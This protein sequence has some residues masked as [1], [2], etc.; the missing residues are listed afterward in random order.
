[1]QRQPLHITQALGIKAKEN[2]LDFFDA[3]LFY[4][5]L[6]FVDPFLLKRS[7]ESYERKLYNRFT[8][9][10]K[11]AFQ[12]SINAK[13]DENSSDELLRFLSF[14]EPKEINLGYTKSS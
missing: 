1:M 4:D 11:I 3:N 8:Q 10:F 5:S 7:P 2:E 13:T 9:Y 6:L 12:K 14:P